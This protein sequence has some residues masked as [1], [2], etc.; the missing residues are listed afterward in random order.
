[1]SKYFYCMNNK[2]AANDYVLALLGSGYIQTKSISRSDFLLID[3]EHGGAR[4]EKIKYY[5]ERIPV[6]IYPHTPYSYWLW[7]GLYTPLPVACNFVV[8]DGAVNGM[9]A[10][11]YPYRV[12]A[13]GFTG[14][15]VSPFRKTS[16]KRLLFAP[17]H[18][19]GDGKHASIK[20]GENQFNA[21]KFIAG[22]CEYFD[23]VTVRY[24]GTIQSNGL[25]C[26]GGTSAIM[27][28]V[29]IYKNANIRE[30]ATKDILNSDIVISC[31]TFGYLAVA[32]GTPSVLYGYKGED[33]GGRAGTVKNYAL[34]KHH[35]EYPMQLEDMS[36]LEILGVR[37]KESPAVGE[38]KRDNIGE[39]FNAEKFVSVIREYVK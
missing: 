27:K 19:F 2:D 7:D 38:W 28:H 32:S 37:E 14:C 10:Y 5:C 15:K 33:V 17:A 11:G 12:E 18:P 1:M 22:H 31:N 23:S 4:F 35:Y 34:Y 29:E 24:S 30:E 3:N 26:F 25:E 6:F 36:I 9:I 20:A 39:N 8:G 13:V 21:A 16:G